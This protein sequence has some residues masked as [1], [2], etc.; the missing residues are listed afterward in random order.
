[1]RQ[2]LSVYC[3]LIVLSHWPHVAQQVAELVAELVF[4]ML[5][6]GT[7]HTSNKFSNLLLNLCPRMLLEPFTLDTCS[8]T[9]CDTFSCA[10]QFHSPEVA[11]A[12]RFVAAHVASVKGLGHKLSNKFGNLCLSPF[13]LGHTRTHVACC[14]CESTIRQPIRQTLA[15]VSRSRST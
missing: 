7:V 14:Q 2:R 12:R 1:M 10:R 4:A 11:A 15:A 8:A 13:T 5:F 9:S 6:N 3:P